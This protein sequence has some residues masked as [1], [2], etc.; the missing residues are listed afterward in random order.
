MKQQMVTVLDPRFMSTRMGAR[1]YPTLADYYTVPVISTHGSWQLMDML[2]I[3]NLQALA[4][5]AN[6][7][8]KEQKR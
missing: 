6:K 7:L 3:E 5:Y 2:P 8:A 1:N 4:K